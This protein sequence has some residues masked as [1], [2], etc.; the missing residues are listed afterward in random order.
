L[1]SLGM[2]WDA[3]KGNCKSRECKVTTDN[4]E[5]QQTQ[6]FASFVDIKNKETSESVEVPQKKENSRTFLVQAE[7]KSRD[8]I[9]KDIAIMNA[10]GLSKNK[11]EFTMKHSKKR[12]G[13]INDLE[14]HFENIHK[15]CG[16]SDS[17]FVNLPSVSVENKSNLHFTWKSVSNNNSQ[18]KGELPKNLNSITLHEP[19][20]YSSN[21]Q[22]TVLASGSGNPSSLLINVIPRNNVKKMQLKPLTLLSKLYN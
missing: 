3:K 20:N 21:G 10:K 12:I 22:G 19:S 18:T 14:P 2:V 6:W 1:E 4:I 9:N 17:L 15:R 8:S 5:D 11:L 7:L 16:D 13:A